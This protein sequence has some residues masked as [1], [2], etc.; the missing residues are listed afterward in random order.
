MSGRIEEIR[1][2]RLILRRARAEDLAG[3]H[4]VLS[5]PAA[6]RYWATPPHRSLDETK[7]WLDSMIADPPGE[8]DDF[9][10]EY[11]GRVIGKAGCWR[12]PEIGFILHP[13]VWGRGLAREALAAIIPYLFEHFPIPA[14]VAD[15]DPRNL[16][17]IGLMN[18]LGFEETGRATGTWRIGEESC[19]SIY[20]AL[21][22]PAEGSEPSAGT[23]SLRA[24]LLRR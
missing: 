17:C 19:D 14:I 15:V 10:V 18:R 13:S 11:E 9:V 4:S 5:D 12:L 7:E 20:F 1:T 24:P 2:D 21:P 6:M 3:F 23:G 22:R 16:A 8:R